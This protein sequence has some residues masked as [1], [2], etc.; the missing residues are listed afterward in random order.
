MM[1]APTPSSSA[2]RS[3]ASK[4]THLIADQ[5]DL[6]LILG[7]RPD[8]LDKLALLQAEIA[9]LAQH[10]A[11]VLELRDAEECDL[12]PIINPRHHAFNPHVGFHIC[13]DEPVDGALINGGVLRKEEH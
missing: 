1:P 9:V 7:H 2:S 5:L 13:R 4:D 8:H 10:N 6:P 12:L 11:N 3:S